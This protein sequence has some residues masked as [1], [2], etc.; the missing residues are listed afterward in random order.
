[1]LVILLSPIFASAQ[2]V[3]ATGV[4]TVYVKPD[5]AHL[6]FSI[7]TSHAK[8]KTANADNKAASDSFFS[9]LKKHNIDEKDVSTQHFNISPTYEETKPGTGI[10]KLV[11]YSVLHRI[12]VRVRDMKLTGVI[13][14]EAVDGN[15]HLSS[16]NFMISNRSKLED[17]ARNLALADAKKRANQMVTKLGSKLGNLRTISESISPQ[18]PYADGRAVG[19]SGGTKIATGQMAISVSVTANWEI[20]NTPRLGLGAGGPNPPN[21]ILGG[22]APKHLTEAEAKAYFDKLKAGGF[23]AYP[24]SNKGKLEYP[25]QDDWR[26][27]NCLGYVMGKNDWLEPGAMGNQKAGQKGHPVYF[28][29]E[30]FKMGLK[31]RIQTRPNINEA[32]LP[33]RDVMIAMYGF[34]GNLLDKGPNAGEN[35]YIF[36]HFA[37]KRKGDTLWTSKLGEKIL[38]QHE[39]LSQLENPASDYGTVMAVYGTNK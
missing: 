28:H 20:N 16:I 30:F 32:K 13:I 8:A 18:S 34:Y 5:C 3:T 23:M 12:S 9:L 39:F 25:K 29:N 22:K 4:G 36:T 19:L 14:D 24:N 27:A 7:S 38:V 17:K 2:G 10:H 11:G 33:V 31:D 6:N 26:K 1:M 37:M 15:V 35:V 21:P